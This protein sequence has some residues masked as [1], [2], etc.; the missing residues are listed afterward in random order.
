MKTLG[1]Y[2][3]VTLTRRSTCEGSAAGTKQGAG[4]RKPEATDIRGA[5]YLRAITVFIAATSPL[6]G[7]FV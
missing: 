7:S 6:S 4:S 1:H 3:P 5:C 2:S